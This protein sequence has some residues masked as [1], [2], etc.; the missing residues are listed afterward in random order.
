MPFLIVWTHSFR[1][2]L[3]FFFL[4]LRG[5]L[6]VLLA[7]V[8]ALVFVSLVSVLFEIV[9]LLIFLY[10]LLHFLGM[11]FLV[12]LFSSSCLPGLTKSH[13]AMAMMPKS[14]V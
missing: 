3:F 10:M 8:D 6:F 13:A 9:L 4:D 7:V 11:F 12:L 5:F 1:R 14:A 2:V